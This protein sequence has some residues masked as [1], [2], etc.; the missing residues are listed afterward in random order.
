MVVNLDFFLAFNPDVYWEGIYVQ[1]Y[2]IHV[3]TCYHYPIMSLFS[4][5]KSP[6][7]TK[8]K[9]FRAVLRNALCDLR[10]RLQHQPG[11]EV[12]DVLGSRDGCAA[13]GDREWNGHEWRGERFDQ[14][15]YAIRE[16]RVVSAD[17]LKIGH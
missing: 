14:T 6:K 13:T 7:K 15:N 12:V 4:L 10:L 5:V 3:Y 9:V 17:Y 11:Q 1:I 2:N 16:C 8:S